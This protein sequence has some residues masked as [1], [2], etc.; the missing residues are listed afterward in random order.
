V[1][2]IGP[3]KFC[4]LHGVSRILA[5]SAAIAVTACASETPPYGELL[6]EK[7]GFVGSGGEGRF[8]GGLIRADAGRAAS[9]SGTMS[10][11][12]SRVP[13]DGGGNMQGAGVED[14]G[15]GDGGSSV[16]ITL[17]LPPGFF[18][19]LDW[20]I[21]GPAGSYSGTVRFGT[22]QSIEFVVGD[23][24]AGDGYTI[25]LSGIDAY[26][27]PCV[28]TSAKFSVEPG[29]T[30]GAGV[31]IQCAAGDGGPAAASISSGNVEVD[32]GVVSSP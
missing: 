30:T 13:F 18:A 24:N 32:A 9:D 28:G 27:Q 12:S 31:L 23:I 10:D 17:N 14:G 15:P 29:Q 5:S 7:I 21:E 3:F 25:T 8:D 11:G 19:S 26:G 20:V 2:R 1:R 16:G 22:A 6:P 4:A